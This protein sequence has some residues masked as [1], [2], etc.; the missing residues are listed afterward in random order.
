LFVIQGAFSPHYLSIE[1]II[2][3]KPN[4]NESGDIISWLGQNATTTIPLDTT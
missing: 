4:G 1:V 3:F 2:D